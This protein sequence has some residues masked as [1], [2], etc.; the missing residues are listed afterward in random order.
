MGKA[1]TFEKEKL[2]CGILY[3]DE[4]RLASVI[5]SLRQLFGPIDY[6]SSPY[7]FS[8]IT[9]YYDKEMGNEVFRIF[10]SFE[11]LVT[12]DRIAEIKT[13]TN[14][15]EEEY[16]E[17]GSRRVNLDPG[18]IGPGKLVLPTTK[19]AAHRI[20][21]KDGIYAELTLF[22][23]RRDYQ[24]LPWTYIDFRMPEVQKM[25]REIRTIYMKQRKTGLAQ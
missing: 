25:L 15:L 19:P 9:P 20:A 24:V 12:P 17:D 11:N 1:L 14:R 5:D 2:I 18:L 3:T 13:A 6:A 8:G 21:L 23:A 10:I 4:E 22:Y 16:S 7:S